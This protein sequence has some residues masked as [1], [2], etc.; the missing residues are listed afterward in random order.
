MD[1]AELGRKGKVLVGVEAGKNSGEI[2]MAMAFL[3]GAGLLSWAIFDF[4]FKIMRG[5]LINMLLG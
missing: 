5:G 3:A 1:W 4:G 2:V